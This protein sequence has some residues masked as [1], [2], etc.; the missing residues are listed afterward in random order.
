VREN[1]YG[2]WGKINKEMLKVKDKS[3]TKTGLIYCRVRVNFRAE[4]LACMSGL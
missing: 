1:L 2:I 4:H 3:T